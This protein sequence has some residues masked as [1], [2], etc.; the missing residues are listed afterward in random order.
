VVSP[1]TRGCRNGRD[2]AGQTTA[3]VIAGGFP[4]SGAD[5]SAFDF[6]IAIVA[7]QVLGVG[8]DALGIN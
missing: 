2:S 1:L 3:V 5:R 8:E 4:V 7:Q 6:S